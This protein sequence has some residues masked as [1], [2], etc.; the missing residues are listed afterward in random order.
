MA[1]PFRPDC[2]LWGEGDYGEVCGGVGVILWFEGQHLN[3][4][5][6]MTTHIS[7][8]HM[9][10]YDIEDNVTHENNTDRNSQAPVATCFSSQ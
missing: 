2:S 6:I 9:L 1:T 7:H 4:S 8:I 10:A 3:I 5:R